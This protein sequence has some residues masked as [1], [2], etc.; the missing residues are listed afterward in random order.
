MR[1]PLKALLPTSLLSA[2]LSCSLVP[3]AVHAPAPAIEGQDVRL[4]LIHTTDVHSRI[5]PYDFDPSFTDN[6]LGLEDDQGPYGGLARMAWIVR[7]IRAHSG[8]TLH[9]DSGDMFQGAIIFNIFHGEAEIRGFAAM[10]V[11]AMVL[12]NHEFDQGAQNFADQYRAWGSFPMLAANYTFESSAQPWSNELADLTLPSYIFDVDGL[13]VGVIGLGNTS[14]LNSIWDQSNSMDVIPED[15]YVVVPEEAKLLRGQGADLIVVLSHSGMDDDIEMARYLPDIDIILGGHHHI[16]LDPPL[17]VTNEISG[18]RIPVVHSSAFAK[19]VGQVDLVVRDGQILSHNYKLHPVDRWVPEDPQVW[20]IL[21]AYQRRLETEYNLD[22]VLGVALEELSRYGTATGDSMLGNF[23]A[24]SI[25]FY[26]G[27]ETDIAVTN[28]L[29][30]R[31][32]IAAGDITLDDLYNSMPFDNTITT[33]FLSGR[34]VQEMLDY[35]SWRST[36]RGCASQIQVSGIQFTMDCRE[37]IARNIEINGQ[38][39]DL[40]GTYELATNNYIAHGGSG[41]EVLERNTTQFDTGISIRD[42]VMAAIQ[43]YGYLPKPGVCE[44]EGRINLDY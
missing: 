1:P 28:T 16:A 2:S 25:R 23:S 41:F 43:R 30:I 40:Q 9:L 15:P 26:Q 29:G 20:E 6:S 38:P 10:G 21:D 31:A 4:T 37:G 18:K 8:R 44:V 42:V 22:Q 7:D 35:A 11:D 17:V 3:T 27:I 36:E 12:G 34:E 33:M 13:H 24:D 19:F 5:L 32:D 14:S 39:L